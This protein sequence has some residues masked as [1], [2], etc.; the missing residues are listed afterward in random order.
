MLSWMIARAARTDDPAPDKAVQQAL[1]H[2]RV[3]AALR[4]VGDGQN[5]IRTGRKL[6][7]LVKYGTC[8]NPFCIRASQGLSAGIRRADPPHKTGQ[9]QIASHP[10][11]RPCGKDAPRPRL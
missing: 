6:F 1:I 7:A 5:A 4:V 3:V 11:R 10:P 2:P 8:A 9:S